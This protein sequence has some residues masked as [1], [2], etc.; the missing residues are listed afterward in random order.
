MAPE[1]MQTGKIKYVCKYCL[2]QMVFENKMN[3]KFTR[4]TFLVVVG[5]NTDDPSS[6]TYP[7]VLSWDSVRI[8]FLNV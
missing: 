7:S 2:T 1:Q 6:I 8:Y 3:G 5:H 4:N